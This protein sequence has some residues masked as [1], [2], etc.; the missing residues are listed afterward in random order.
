M[1]VTELFQHAA[2]D[3]K[4]KFTS[5]TVG[6]TE[7]NQWLSWS[8]EELRSFGEVHDWP[9]LKARVE[10]S[11]SGTSGALVSNFKKMAG[12]LEVDGK[13]F[14]E[15]DEDKFPLYGS[16]TQVFHQGYNNGWYV[17]W[18]KTGANVV[19]PIHIYPTSL[20]TTTDQ[21]VMRNPMY[22]VKRLKARIFKYRQDPIFSELETESSVM[23]NQMIEN[24]FYKHQ[25][26]KGGPLTREEEYGF[27][28]GVD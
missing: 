20:A 11:T 6:S 10:I 2:S 12:Y 4:G 3:A 17:A 24:E 22:L 14:D 21:I 7:W 5:P 19:A 27:E 1:N 25:Q 18:K 13:L 9:E 8:N 23:L 28:L 16:D 26:Y 15:V